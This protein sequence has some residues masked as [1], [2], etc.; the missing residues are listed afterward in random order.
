MTVKIA[1]EFKHRLTFSLSPDVARWVKVK[2]QTSNVS[3]SALV[4]RCLHSHYQEDREALLREGYLANYEL[5]RDIARGSLSLQ[6]KI[7]PKY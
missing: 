2:A 4:E 1:R 6:R 3:R 5:S 7:L